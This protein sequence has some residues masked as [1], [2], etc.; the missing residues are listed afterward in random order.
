[1]RNTHIYTTISFVYS[2]LTISNYIL[3]QLPINAPN[4]I[5]SIKKCKPYKDIATT[6]PTI[7]THGLESNIFAQTW[8]YITTTTISSLQCYGK[9]PTKIKHTP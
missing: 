1:M 3:I 4:L 9:G 2:I 5:L 7:Q 8:A 6:K